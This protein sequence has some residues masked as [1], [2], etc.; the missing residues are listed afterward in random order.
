MNRDWTEWANDFVIIADQWS[1][2]STEEKAA[3][4]SGSGATAGRAGFGSLT[5]ETAV[6]ATASTSVASEVGAC[7]G[8][9]TVGARLAACGIAVCG[10]TVTGGAGCG[11]TVTGGSGCGASARTAGWAKAG[12][13]A[14]SGLGSALA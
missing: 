10:A 12:V 9:L 2:T 3:R 14:E 5:G 11:A 7:S 1:Q 6:V 8:A 4:S 13:S